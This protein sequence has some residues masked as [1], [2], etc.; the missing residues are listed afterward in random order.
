MAEVDWHA[1][2]RCIFFSLYEAAR[3]EMGGVA[4][5]TVMLGIGEVK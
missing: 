1:L 4:T 5:F 2:I 3:V